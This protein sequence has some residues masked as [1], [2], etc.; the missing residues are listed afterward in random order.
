MVSCFDKDEPI[1]KQNYF[2]SNLECNNRKSL[3]YIFAKKQSKD[4]LFFSKNAIN[5][6]NQ[7]NSKWIVGQ[8]TGKLYFDTG[9][10]IIFSIKKIN[11]RKFYITIKNSSNFSIN[12]PIVFWNLKKE[13]H[14]VFPNSKKSWGFGKVIYEEKK[15]RF[16]SHIFECDTNRVSLYLSHSKDLKN[17]IRDK[18]PT[19]TPLDFK[20]ISWNA[21]D[22]NGKMTVTPL[23]SDIIYHEKKYYVFVYGDNSKNNTY[24][25]LLTCDSLN[26]EYKI[27]KQ[28]ILSPNKKS[29]FSNHDVYFPK[30]VRYKDQWLMFYTSKNEKNEEVI[31]KAISNDLISWTTIKED[32]IYK[33]N[34]WNQNR[35]N[36]LT[37]Q[38]QNINDTILIW[39]TGTK[40]AKEN[41]RVYKKGNVLDIAIGKFY[42]LDGGNTFIEFKGNPII[43]GCPKLASENDHIGACFQEILYNN[44]IHTIYHSKGIDSAHYKIK[45]RY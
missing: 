24:I 39:T 2:I 37:A 45:I 36:Q 7:I 33:N 43:G 28:P 35:K 1:E 16:T 22:K 18:N 8:G 31:S 21:P 10:E 4:T 17:W 14:F 34:G 42:S 19:L 30:I 41:N 38:V 5:I 3:T 25:G 15:N 44:K 13:P 27:K 9:K 40:I 11:I 12:K 6:F 29:K 23:V 26:G 32:I 20:N